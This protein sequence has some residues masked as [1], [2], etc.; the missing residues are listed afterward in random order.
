MPVY[1][2]AYLNLAYDR[3]EDMKKEAGRITNTDLQRKI[4]S[5]FYYLCVV[6]LQYVAPIIMCMFFAFMY[7]TLGGFSWTG[8]TKVEELV[9]QCPIEPP[10][11]TTS[12]VDAVENLVDNVAEVIEESNIFSTAKYFQTSLQ[13]L[14]NVCEKYNLEQCIIN[15]FFIFRF[16]RLKSIEVFWDSL[17]GGHASFGS[18]LHH[19]A[20][21]INRI[22]QN[23]RILI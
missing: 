16:L 1:L 21:F 13:G 3:I 22:S 4:T 11:P 14:K 17:L 5:I 6:T 18:Q 8:T 2:Q 10:L 15:F 7:K 9:G 12:P 23:H 20:C 19:L